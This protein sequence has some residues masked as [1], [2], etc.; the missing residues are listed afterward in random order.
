MMNDV[1]SFCGSRNF[2]Q[3]NVQYIYRLEG[4]LLVVN[5][6][7]CEECT[8]CGERYYEGPALE[9]IEREFGRIYRE[10][11]KP[12]TEMTVPVQEYAAVTG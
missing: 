11:K 3:K 12:Q 4:K 9:R 10:G 8:Y 6:V 2:V 1:C 5:G 7:P